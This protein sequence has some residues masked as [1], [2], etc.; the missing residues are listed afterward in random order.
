MQFNLVVATRPGA[1]QHQRLGY[2]DALVMVQ[3]LEKEPGR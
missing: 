1:F 3:A 2:A